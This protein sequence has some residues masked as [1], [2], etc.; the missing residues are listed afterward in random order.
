MLM[1]VR[2]AI[3][4]SGLVLS[5]CGGNPEGAFGG[6]YTGTITG[7]SMTTSTTSGTATTA[8]DMSMNSDSVHIRPSQATPGNMVVQIDAATESALGACEFEFQPSGMTAMIA[9]LLCALFSTVPPSSME[10]P[11]GRVARR[12][13]ILSCMRS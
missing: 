7:T 2:T 5:A 4:A 3:V 10:A 12:A 11:G 1:N 6:D 9:T 13:S 8:N